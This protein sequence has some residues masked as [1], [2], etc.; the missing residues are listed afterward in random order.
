MRR[1][2]ESGQRYY[3]IGQRSI[4]KVLRFARRAVS[5]V[6]WLAFAMLAGALFAYVGLVEGLTRGEAIL[7][8]LLLFTP[9]LALV[10]FALVLRVLRLRFDPFAPGP[11]VRLLLTT[12][13]LGTGLLLSPAYWAS[14]VLLAASSFI[15][16]PVAVLLA[17]R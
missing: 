17:L 7:V 16:V 6:S 15:V 2:V 14:V 10:H 8:A 3:D 9:P 11:W 1:H 12:R 4:F 13:V 5:I